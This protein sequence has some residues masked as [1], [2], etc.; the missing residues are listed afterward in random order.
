MSDRS[1]N[2]SVASPK[3]SPPPMAQ[4]LSPSTAVVGLQLEPND[5]NSLMHIAQGLLATIRKREA[6]HRIE[7]DSWC[8]QMA[9]QKLRFKEALARVQPREDRPD[10]YVLN[11]KERAP[12]FVIP[13]QDGYYQPAWWVRQ[14]P[15][16]RVAGLPKSHSPGDTPYIAE[17]YAECDGDDED[18]NIILPLPIWLLSLLKGSASMYGRLVQ[19]VWN[20]G[21]WPLQAEVS[22]FRELEIS[23]LDIKIRIDH[24]QAEQRGIREAQEASRAR[25]ELGRLDHKVSNLRTVGVPDTRNRGF[26]QRRAAQFRGNM[27]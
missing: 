22:R 26:Q 17:V 5:P 11:I 13:I 27:G 19:E 1:N 23:L 20:N 8:E 25:L 12:N 2:A 10:G 18:D 21:D 3:G 9:T 15:D 24:L 4:P 7:S 6:E 14:L 16:G